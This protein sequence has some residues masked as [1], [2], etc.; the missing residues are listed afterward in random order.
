MKIPNLLISTI[1]L[2]VS[3]FVVRSLGFLY[4]IILTKFIGEYGL[5]IYHIIFNILMMCLAL[6]TT[7]IPTTLSSLVAKSKTLKDNYKTKTLFVSSIYVSFFI[8]F[9]MSL[10][11]YIFSKDLSF[12]FLRD[13]NLNLFFIAICPAIVIM[14]LSNILRG[15]YYGLNNVLIPAISQVLEQ[16]SRILFVLLISYYIKGENLS[17]YIS[18][19]AISVGEIISI[20]YLIINLYKYFGLKK[21]HTINISDFFNSSLE[22][23]KLSIPIT[24]SRISNVLFHS[25]SSLLIPSRL[26]LSGISYQNAI[27]IFGII[28]G[29]VMPIIYLPFMLGSALV[30]NLIPNLSSEIALKNYQK[31][32]IKSFYCL[33]LSFLFGIFLSIS[34]YFFS[35]EICLFL[36]NSNTLATKYLKS[37]FLV[38]L[39]LSLNQ[40]LSS[41]LHSIGKEI[42]CGVVSSLSVF[43]E[44]ILIYILTPKHGIYGYIH[45][46]TFVSVV[47]FLIYTFSFL[48]NIKNLTT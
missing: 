29:M 20:F 9:F 10:I 27:S 45:T 25:I 42:F 36:Y 43:C 11:I 4:K 12:I 15:Y 23:I 38:P 7:G 46:L 30:V 19:I 3:N 1:I 28:S 13:S 47:A 32:K 44:I 26:V 6:T 33:F 37:L 18:L 14:T 40:T 17:C 35:D 41:I 31:I 39:F 22:T 48:K 8:S 24:C 16:I 2:F 21:V 5:G 34:I